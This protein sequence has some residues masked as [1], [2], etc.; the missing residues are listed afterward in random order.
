MQCYETTGIT[1]NT[2]ILKEA[3]EDILDYFGEDVVP[4]ELADYSV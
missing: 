1:N 2:V 3:S 4:T